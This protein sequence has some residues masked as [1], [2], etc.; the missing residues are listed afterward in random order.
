MAEKKQLLTLR[1]DLET[2]AEFN[3]AA[4]V[5]R[6]RS[7][8]SFL[9]NYVVA[10]INEAKKKVTP[11]EFQEIV[12]EEKQITLERSRIKSLSSQ[13]TGSAKVSPVRLNHKKQSVPLMKSKVR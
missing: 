11:D 5:F 12:E 1:L 6:A 7:V 9:H 3:A 13:K 2:L 8:S 10:Q 4:R